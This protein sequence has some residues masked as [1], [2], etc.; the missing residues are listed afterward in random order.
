MVAFKRNYDKYTDAKQAI[1]NIVLKLE[2]GNCFDSQKGVSKSALGRCA[3]PD[4]TFRWPQG[5][6][7]AAAK[8]VRQML[9]AKV[10]HMYEN[11]Y[12]SRNYR[13]AL[14]NLGIDLNELP[15]TSGLS[16]STES[17]KSPRP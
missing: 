14:K 13:E 12:L 4:Y 16:A 10:L 5:A 7:F 8:I 17:T 1:I 6:A 9:D 3:F 15:E 11:Y 2:A